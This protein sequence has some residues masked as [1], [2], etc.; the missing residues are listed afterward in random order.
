MKTISSARSLNQRIIKDWNLE[1]NRFG[2]EL[3]VYKFK[4][5]MPPDSNLGTDAEV[6]NLCDKDSVLKRDDMT[7]HNSFG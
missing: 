7:S 2:F 4:Y 3:W 1:I 6:N 5:T